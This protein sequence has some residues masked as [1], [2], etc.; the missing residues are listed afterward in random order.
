MEIPNVFY[1]VK[2]NH[3]NG[4]KAPEKSKE[5]AAQH[6]EANATEEAS[7]AHPPRF[8]GRSCCFNQSIPDGNDIWYN[9]VATL[10]LCVCLEV[11][12][13]S[14]GFP[15]LAQR[16]HLSSALV[17]MHNLNLHLDILVPLPLC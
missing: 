7:L 13:N 16:W 8:Q 12:A 11:F 1:P 6:G 5:F 15:F 9:F 14:K 3:Q 10:H 4:S 17:T 2:V